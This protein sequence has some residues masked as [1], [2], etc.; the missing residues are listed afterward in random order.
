MRNTFAFLLLVGLAVGVAGFNPAD[1]GVC[2]AGYEEIVV[3]DTLQCAHPDGVPFNSARPTSFYSIDAEA[4]ALDCFG[5]GTDGNRLQAVFVAE[6]GASLTSADRAAIAQGMV[7]V[8]S[9]YRTSSRVLGETDFVPRWAHTPECEPSIEVVQVPVGVLSDFAA[10][11][12]AVSEQGYDRPDRKYIMWTDSAAYCGIAAVSVDDSKVGNQNDGHHP[13]YARIDRGCWGY[14]GSVVAHEV[15]HTLGAVQPTAPNAT[16]Y[17]H[18]TDEYDIM[19]YVDG[20]GITMSVACPDH[21]GELLLDCNNDDYFHPDPPPGNWLYSH[22]NI[23]DSSFVQRVP[24]VQNSKSD[25]DQD[26]APGFAD[27]DREG[28]HARAIGW[29]AARGVTRGCEPGRFCPDQPVTRGQMA[30]FLHRFVPDLAVTAGPVGFGDVAAE[31]PFAGDIAWLVG[32]GLT[33]GCDEGSFCPDQPVSRAQMAAF[34]FRVFAPG[35]VVPDAGFA[36][37]PADSPFRSEIAWLAHMGISNGCGNS[38]F[39]PDAPVTRG[40]MASF[41]YRTGQIYLDE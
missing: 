37:V 10:T 21:G 3:G 17:G 16:P 15:T 39:C 32:T 38:D 40:Q 25:L 6:G 31:G 14:Q 33:R 22:W 24:V 18:C 36:D 11:I 20:P 35:V 2:P 34:L 26:N 27:V 1:A 28:P 8:Q 29:L 12:Q 19:C 4:R 30:A 23:A 5:T 13:G 9:V 7:N 41:L